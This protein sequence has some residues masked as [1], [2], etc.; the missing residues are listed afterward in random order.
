MHALLPRFLVPMFNHGARAL[1]VDV[2]VQFEF[3]K[4]MTQFSNQYWS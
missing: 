4:C 1:K 2:G 3:L